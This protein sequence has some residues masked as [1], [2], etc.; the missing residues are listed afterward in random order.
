MTIDLELCVEIQ[1]ATLNHYS[2]IYS[3]SCQHD[4]WL[5]VFSKRLY[6]FN[7]IGQLI[8][9]CKETETQQIFSRMCVIAKKLKICLPLL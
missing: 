6:R 4:D 7:R 8:I 5:D 3:K 9:D 1:S 2:Q